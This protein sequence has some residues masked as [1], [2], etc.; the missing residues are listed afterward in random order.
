VIGRAASLQGE[1]NSIRMNGWPFLRVTVA[2]MIYFIQSSPTRCR[3]I[4]IRSSANHPTPPFTKPF[5]SN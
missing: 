1:L 4:R 2:Q 3:V 5:R